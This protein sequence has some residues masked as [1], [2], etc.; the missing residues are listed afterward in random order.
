MSEAGAAG[1]DAGL[2]ASPADRDRRRRTNVFMED[3]DVQHMDVAPIRHFLTP[4]LAARSAL[5]GSKS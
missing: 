2:L 3:V 4:E 5:F 1:C